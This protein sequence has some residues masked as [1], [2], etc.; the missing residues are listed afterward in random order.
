MSG[1]H[2]PQH[3]RNVATYLALFALVI[4]AVGLLFLTTLVMPAAAGLVLVI[5][6]FFGVVALHY[7][8]WG[9]WLSHRI[10]REEEEGD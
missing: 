3:E 4:V 8:V 1:Q 7:V 2:S 5:L 6:G 9:W 10:N